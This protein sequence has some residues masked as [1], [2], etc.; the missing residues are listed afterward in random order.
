MK[1]PNSIAR[2][3]VLEYKFFAR[4]VSEYEAYHW[5]RCHNHDEETAL[6]VILKWVYDRKI[7]ES[8][9]SKGK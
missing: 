4:T 2:Y 8:L 5:M 6:R 9:F 3:D 7:L 1:H